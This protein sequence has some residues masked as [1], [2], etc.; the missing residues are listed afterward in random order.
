MSLGARSEDV[1]LFGP[2]SVAW[3][4]H[5]DPCMLIGG[6]RAL[7]IQ[8]LNPLAMAAVDQHSDFREDPWGRLRR[9]SEYVTTT[10]FGDT[11]S[12]LAAGARVRAI[13]RRVRGV[14]PVTGRSY[15]AGDPEL[16]LWIHVVEVDSFVTAYRRYGGHLSDADADLYVKEM[17]RAAELV[18]LHEQDV[19]HTLFE[20]EEYMRGVDNL[21]V[22]P[23]AR[24]G[25]RFLLFPPAPALGRLAW[26]IPATAAVGILP[27]IVRDLYGLPWFEP[28]DPAVRIGVSALC[29]TLR[30][31]VPPPLPVREALERARM[32]PDTA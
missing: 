15:S 3:R 7:L 10:I 19:P 32:S 6:I 27:P 26:A 5:Q 20:I 14:D 22:T 16:L 18:G 28:A 17:V 8:A 11:A 12:A 13:H 2:N 25:L 30:A 9:T 23:A 31:L 29:K 21:C 4:L 1:G 24:E